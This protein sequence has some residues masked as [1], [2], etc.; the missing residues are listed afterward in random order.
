MSSSSRTRPGSRSSGWWAFPM[1]RD[2]LDRRIASAV[3]AGDADI[4]PEIRRAVR[5]RLAAR[6]V[7]KRRFWALPKFWAAAA[8]AAA[9]FAAVIVFQGGPPWGAKREFRQIRAQFNV[10]GKNISIVWVM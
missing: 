5:E 7:R 10:P 2:D 1:E 6:T 8:A 3:R 4:P 9:V